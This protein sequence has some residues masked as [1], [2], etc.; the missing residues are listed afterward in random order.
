ML[1]KKE[2][3]GGTWVGLL[4]LALGIA[5]GSLARPSRWRSGESSADATVERRALAPELVPAATRETPAENGLETIEL[6]IPESSAAALQAVR[7][8][9]LE[10]GIIQQSG[11]QG[12]VPAELVHR[13][14]RMAAELRIK[15]DWTDHVEGKR[16][17]YRIH[18]TEATFLGMREFSIQAPATRGYLWEWLVHQAARRE[19]VLVP[20]STFVDVVQNGHAMGV[21]FV[22][23]HFEKELLEAQ[24]R[25][26][27]PIV[28]WDES[29]LW[30]T[31]LLEGA[32]PARGGRP[33]DSA[34]TEPA[35]TL[36]AAET[37][38]YGE[39]PLSRVGDLNRA[40]FAALDEL[41]GLRALALAQESEV[42]RLRVQQTMADLRGRTLEELVDVDAL[43]RAHAL[44]S[45][46]QLEHSLAWHNMRFYRDPVLARLEPILFD[47]A[48]Q[49]PGGRDPVPLRAEGLLGA[50][51]ASPGYYD[52]LFAHLGRLL[53]SDWLDDFF[54]DIAPDLARFERALLSEGP[55]PT[56]GT[57]EEMKQRL[58]A[59][60]LY[61]RTACLPDD[62]ISFESSYALAGQGEDPGSGTLEVAAWSTTRSPVALERFLFSNGSSSLAADWIASGQV[63]ARAWRDPTRPDAEPVV[64]LPPDGRPITF[65][66]P[67]NARLANL[68]TVD[69][70]TRAVRHELE[71]D[72]KLDLDVRAAYRLLT[73]EDGREERL[74]FRKKPGTSVLVDRPA[75]PEL[76]Q[77]LERHPYL[78][79][80]A[81]RAELSIA[82]GS[83]DMSGDLVLPSGLGLRLGAGTT[84]R[85]P[86]GA[87][88][89]ADSPLVFEGTPEAPVVLEP[90]AGA[91][92]WQGVV[93][94]GSAGRSRWTHTIVRRADAAAR[95]GWRVSGGVTFYRAPLSMVGG[96]LEKSTAEDALHV[97]AADVALEGVAFLDAAGGGFDGDVV[98]GRLAGCRFQGVAGNGIDLRGGSLVVLGGT[99]RALGGTACAIGAA[100][101]ARIEGIAVEDVLGAVASRDAAEVEV[102]RITVQGARG[103]AL[104][105]TVEEPQFGP[106]RLDAR[107]VTLTGSGRG[108][109]FAESGCTLAI[110]G[111]PVPT[112]AD[113]EGG[114]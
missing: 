4:I 32:V 92:G 19:N 60:T 21:Y 84:L 109:A 64:V 3:T 16:W 80:D 45:L 100:G 69:K 35:H 17:S 20:R 52:G 77:A 87:L 30:S 26:E 29:T 47:N 67:M 75:A 93:V 40:L 6:V 14:R 94:L 114:R 9:A 82:P 59:E 107:A 28:V 89:L 81:A 15:G 12:M 11:E 105:A 27:G 41:K 68:E 63:G 97:F 95:G 7:D 8:A 61:L 78:H 43:A 55:L 108:D 83:W 91:A 74:H 49:D 10:R 44:A 56:G 113:A 96:A 110:D 79:Y 88:L 2:R 99:F 31:L 86:A 50:F 66:F 54:A 111:V 76:A 98:T 48:A 106:A 70:V 62:A 72:T 18:L 102:E 34:L 53:R 85:F 42:E 51:A 65:R 39:K 90:A 101:R 1:T 23:E 103:Y 112:T 71:A 46:F 5:I 33:L 24:G 36:A 37:R 58:R 38:A 104:S 13:G 73:A 22:E 25:R 57:A